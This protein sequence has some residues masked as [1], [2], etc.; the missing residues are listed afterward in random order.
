MTRGLP[1]PQR[2][3]RA[4]FILMLLGLVAIGLAPGAMAQGPP[5]DCGARQDVRDEPDDVE[6]RA[7]VSSPHDLTPM[8]LLG[9]S[10]WRTEE[11]LGLSGTLAGDPRLDTEATYYYWLSIEA[12]HAAGGGNPTTWT[13]QRTHTYQEI[14]GMYW[15]DRAEYPVTWDGLTFWFIVPW[16]DFE[17]EFGSRWPM[18]I[19]SPR[20][21][22]QGPYFTDDGTV[23]YATGLAGWN[24]WAYDH[25]ELVALPYCPVLEATANE[26]APAPSDAPGAYANPLPMADSNSTER[27]AV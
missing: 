27:H 21:S 4:W 8:D 12:E 7:P 10:I 11:G 20:L 5:S 14:S 22:S 1:A 9:V 16:S 3:H 15:E 26:T 19:G 17:A 24:D 23:N 6:G 13:F 2:M 25:T 18:D